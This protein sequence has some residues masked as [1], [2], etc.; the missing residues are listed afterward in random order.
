MGKV[1][2]RG[3]FIKSDTSEPADIDVYNDNMDRIHNEVM[4]LPYAATDPSANI[5]WPGKMVIRDSGDPTFFLPDLRINK[6]N[7]FW[8]RAI[9]GSWEAY[10]P[11]SAGVTVGNGTL[12]GRF[13]HV[14]SILFCEILLIWG[15]TTAF[16][17]SPSFGTPSGYKLRVPD[18]FTNEMKAGVGT[19]MARCGAGSP[20]TLYKG[21]VQRRVTAAGLDLDPRTVDAPALV[22]NSTRPATW[23]TGN[24]LHIQ[25]SGE[26][27]WE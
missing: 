21:R 5:T 3:G 22:L 9:S 8:E 17:G 16:T 13:C 4:S 10:T 19:W 2:E 15:S 12:L 7:N 20:P 26:A 18:E 23:T 1:T 24:Q 14:G 11:E 25:V 6:A 27:E